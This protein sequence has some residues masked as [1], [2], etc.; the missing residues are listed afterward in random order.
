LAVAIQSDGK[1]ILAGNANTETTGGNVIY[2]VG[3]ARY[4][5]DGS[6]DTSFD[7]DGKVVTSI[8][9]YSIC[10]DVA[11]QSNGRIVVAG[12]ATANSGGS[13]DF[14]LAGY[15]SNGSLD[16]NF[17]VGGR[18]LTPVSNGEDRAFSLV[19]KPD[20]KLIL[21]GEAKQIFG[22]PP[23]SE[24]NGDF[25]V[26]QYNSNGTTDTAFGFGGKVITPVATSDI[27]YA[28]ALQ[29]DGKLVVAGLAA[30]LA[31]ISSIAVLRYHQNGTLDQSFGYKIPGS[32]STVV[33]GTIDEARA[34]TIQPDGKIV[35]VGRARVTNRYYFAV[36]RQN[37]DGTLDSNFGANGTLITKIGAGDTD[38][39]ARAVAL[40][41]D[42]KIV[43]AGRLYDASTN[44]GL[45]YFALARYNPDGSLDQT[46]DGDGTVIVPAANEN[47]EAFAVAVQPNGK[48]VVAGYY[49]TLAGSQSA[50]DLAV[51]RLES[52]GALDASFDEDGIVTTDLGSGSE[53]AFSLALQSDG[54]ILIAGSGGINL[55]FAIVRYNTN[56]SLDGEFGTN[57]KVLTPVGTSLDEIRSLALQPDGKI[58]AAGNARVGSQSDFA[59]VRYNPNGTLDTTFDGDGKAI[60]PI[61]TNSTD[62]A[63]SVLVQANGRIIIVGSSTTG[64]GTSFNSDIAIVRYTS[65]G[66]LDAGFGGDG[67]IITDYAGDGYSGETAA[68]AALVPSGKLIV[69]G[70][71]R[72]RV[73]TGFSGDRRS[74]LLARYFTD[75][76]APF[77]FDGDGRSDVSV[78]RPD[79]GTWY[80][81][82]SQNGSTGISFGFS[83]D[84]IVPADYD[85]DGKTDVAVY[86]SGTWYLQRSAQ[87]F[88]GIAFGDGNDISQPAD[89]DG[90]GKAELAV[91]RPSNGT[92]YALNLA[93]NQ[94]NAFSFGSSGDKPVAADYDGDGKTDLAVFR[95]GTW[96]IQRSQLGFT[97][98]AFGEATDKPVPAD[99]DGDGKADVAVFR[100]SNGTWYLQRSQLGFTGIGFGLGTDLPVPA[101]YDGDGKADVSVFRDGTWYLNRST[102]GFTGVTF[103]AATDKPVPN[104][105]VP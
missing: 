11:L 39:E 102:S 30:P 72:D 46:F 83:T 22:V 84:K 47:N 81:L 75:T 90:D 19:V 42:G 53:T 82:Q 68:S 15:N 35:S 85:G 94:F 9:Q 31:T 105:F 104:A 33:R 69:A 20:D 54:K 95:N 48:I 29:L 38:S 40:Q 74:F 16:A 67:I 24:A 1:I 80:L 59:V 44:L 73:A 26:V 28:A 62:L 4:N 25:A 10:F 45:F 79:N 88:T 86:R 71:I 57:G 63:S 98:I 77:D 2:Q 100:P 97:G 91:F 18:V 87:G 60:T 21:A 58:I 64:T 6:P 101:D 14:A 23:F 55:D 76:Q 13:L 43:V 37:A 34:M 32:V 61:T 92:W 96:Y 93:N 70:T 41:A 103:G 66:T 12:H 52:N 65:T 7:S 78:F 5:S 17:G 8:G 99:Y 36:A 56:G 27:A 89:Y 51:V 3:L 49:D 50:Y